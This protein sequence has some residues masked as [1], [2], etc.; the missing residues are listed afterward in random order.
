VAG[1]ADLERYHMFSPLRETICRDEALFSGFMVVSPTGGVVGVRIAE[2]AC[3]PGGNVV[4]A[5]K[6]VD[7]CSRQPEALV[8]A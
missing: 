3:P 5:W 2:K 8:A 4:G 1:I 7:L 6:D